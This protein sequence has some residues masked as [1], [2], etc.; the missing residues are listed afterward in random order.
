MI[1]RAEDDEAVKFKAIVINRRREQHVLHGGQA[2]G[3]EFQHFHAQAGFGIGL[4]A[5][6]FLGVLPGLLHALH[7]ARAPA[8]RAQVQEQI[9]P[10]DPLHLRFGQDLGQAF[11]L[12][13]AEN[14][15]LVVAHVEMVAPDVEELPQ[16]I[17]PAVGLEDLL[18]L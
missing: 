10:P 17:V 18:G 6:Q 14:R 8:R 7:P 9:R 3:Q 4:L 15:P 11:A 12:G 2:F 5:L 1:V 16:E 13:H